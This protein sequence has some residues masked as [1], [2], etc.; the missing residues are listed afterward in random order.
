MKVWR[1][2]LQD[3]KGSLHIAKA[4]NTEMTQP[5]N[6]SHNRLHS[7][8]NNN[9]PSNM[10][11]EAGIDNEA[12]WGR[13]SSLHS[14]F[15]IESDAAKWSMGSGNELDWIPPENLSVEVFNNYLDTV[16][17]STNSIL[18]DVNLATKVA[19]P[20]AFD[21]FDIEQTELIEKVKKTNFAQEE[22]THSTLSTFATKY[23]SV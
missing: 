19:K 16:H 4:G 11:I 9:A 7:S 23:Y 21:N 17:E 1:K 18:G 8:T 15:V 22:N 13:G 10:E 14:R 3:C 12:K 2:G 20:G 6:V 5:P